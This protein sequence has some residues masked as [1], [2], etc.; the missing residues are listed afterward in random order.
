MTFHT[1]A[2]LAFGYLDAPRDHLRY[3]GAA[4]TFI[5]INEASQ[6]RENQL[7]YIHTRLRRPAN[8][9]VPLQMRYA[10]NPGDI[11]HDF[12]KDRFIDN[13][14][15][16]EREF[17][18]S[19]LEDNPHLDTQEYR[20]SLMGLDPL[21]RA[22]LM[23]GDWNMRPDAQ[24]F[25]LAKLNRVPKDAVPGNVMLFRSWDFAA[26]AP[27]IGYS[28]PDYTVGTL[29]GYSQGHYFII[30]CE[31]MRGNPGE[32]E[33]V[34]ART[35]GADGQQTQII[36]EVEPGSAGIGRLDWYARSV[37]PGFAVHGYRPTGSKAT[38]AGLL[39][40]AMANGNVS[41]VEGCRFVPEMIDEMR[42]FGQ[43]GHDD[44]VDSLSQLVAFVGVRTPSIWR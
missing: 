8:A 9:N 1:G 36:V 27:K 28:D 26:T 38:R 10:S 32:V 15:M 19:K 29:V 30:D 41:I 33:H 23:N 24:F 4:Y 21:T 7:R 5:G 14:V 37:L 39:G 44:I 12:L 40:A 42:G 16:G 2:T 31:R 3:Q 35:A 43:T 22:Q 6:I 34:I 25:D 18:P 20:Q 13:P 11:S 17:I